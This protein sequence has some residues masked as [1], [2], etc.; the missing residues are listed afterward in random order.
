MHLFNIMKKLKTHK[1]AY[2][3]CPKFGWLLRIHL[4]KNGIPVIEQ[5]SP[6]HTCEEKDPFFCKI[7]EPEGYFLDS[8]WK[9]SMPKE[10]VKPAG[11]TWPDADYQD[12]A[13]CNKCVRKGNTWCTKHKAYV[14]SAMTCKH[15]IKAKFEYPHIPEYDESIPGR[16]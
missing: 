7:Y 3:S 5:S 14:S 9:L 1:Y 12:C 4:D 8:D 13:H 15:W 11:L 6:V 2:A 10:W 16:H